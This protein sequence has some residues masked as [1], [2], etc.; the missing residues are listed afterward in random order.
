MRPLNSV[1]RPHRMPLWVFLLAI[2]LLLLALG[3]RWIFRQRSPEE[4]RAAHETLRRLRKK[5]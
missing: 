1:V 5:P 2:L 3:A 4:M